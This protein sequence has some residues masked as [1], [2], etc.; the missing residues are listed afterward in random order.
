M[1]IIYYAY[2]LQRSGRGSNQELLAPATREDNYGSINF[3]LFYF[4]DKLCVTGK[5][6]L[7]FLP[8]V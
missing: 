1:K 8:G 2:L 3:K 7:S 5:Y 4:A 6:N